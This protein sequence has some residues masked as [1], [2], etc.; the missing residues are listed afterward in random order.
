MSGGYQDPVT[1]QVPENK[2]IFKADTTSVK[3]VLSIQ[4][5]KMALGE[6]TLAVL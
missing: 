6:I 3:Q 4:E 2:I 1:R 5:Y